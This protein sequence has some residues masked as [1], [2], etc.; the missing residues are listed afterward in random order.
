MQTQ[1]TTTTQAHQQRMRAIA[2]RAVI[3]LGY[4]EHWIGQ[5]RNYPVTENY[6]VTA[7]DSMIDEINNRYPNDSDTP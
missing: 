2:R 1:D 3:D 6:C 4:L 5:Q 7:L